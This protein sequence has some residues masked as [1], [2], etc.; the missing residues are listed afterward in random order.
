M[1]EDDAATKAGLI[2]GLSCTFIFLVAAG[3]FI[4]KKKKEEYAQLE[5]GGCAED[6]FKRFVDE[7]LCS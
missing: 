1:E 3:Y 5:E 4:N 6:S 7:E 2:V